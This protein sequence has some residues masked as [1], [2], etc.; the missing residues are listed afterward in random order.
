MDKLPALLYLP[1]SSNAF[2]QS[3]CFSCNSSRVIY[4][5]SNTKPIKELKAK[6]D[7]R[8]DVLDKLVDSLTEIY[9]LHKQFN[10][11]LKFI[12]MQRKMDFYVSDTKASSMIP[13]ISQRKR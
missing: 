4:P 1:S 13:F 5:K 10:S 7:N 9:E 11:S 8:K 3:P 6:R 2:T 12:S